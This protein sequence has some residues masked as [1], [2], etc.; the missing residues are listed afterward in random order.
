MKN[1]LYFQAYL[2]FVI[3]FTQ[4]FRFQIGGVSGHRPQ[5]HIFCVK[6]VIHKYVQEKK[7]IILICYDISAFFDMEVLGDLDLEQEP[8]LVNFFSKVMERRQRNGW[9]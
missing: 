7:M 9:I 3:S 5:E 2:I 1:K 8:E 6:S 4:T